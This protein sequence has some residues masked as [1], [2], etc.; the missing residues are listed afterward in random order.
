MVIMGSPHGAANLGKNMAH[1][2]VM[3]GDK[4]IKLTARGCDFTLVFDVHR[5]Q[6]AMYTVNAM[7]RTYNRGY[8]ISKA[9]SVR[10]RSALPVASAARLSGC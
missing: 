8:A 4:E 3:T 2:I 7:V 1:E 5:N 6:W 10:T 9:R